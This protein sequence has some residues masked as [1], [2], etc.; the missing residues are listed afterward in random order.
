M[1]F[2]TES[3]SVYEVNTDSK[4][5]RR[6]NGI[7]DPTPRIGK[8]GEWKSYQDIFPNPPTIGSQVMIV[9]GAETEM[10]PG[11]M[12]GTA[13]PTTITSFVVSVK[14]ERIPFHK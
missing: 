5:I 8:A 12:P 10:L 13:I 4:K 3:N 11:T 14:D 2:Q 9:W 6:V 1:F 7:K